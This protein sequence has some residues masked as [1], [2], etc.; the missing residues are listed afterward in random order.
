MQGESTRID[1]DPQSRMGPSA[2]PMALDD[3]ASDG[4][5]ADILDDLPLAFDDEEWP[6]QFGAAQRGIP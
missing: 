1:A 3:A 6:A 2:W 5:Q 4:W